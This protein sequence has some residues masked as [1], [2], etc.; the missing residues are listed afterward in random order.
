MVNRSAAWF[1][2]V[3]IGG[4]LLALL[5]VPLAELLLHGDLALW[6]HI[7]LITVVLT[8]MAGGAAAAGVAY[9][10]YQARSVAGGQQAQ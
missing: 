6:L 7:P 9:L 4:G 2:T 5:M 10:E 8:L 1:R 3:A